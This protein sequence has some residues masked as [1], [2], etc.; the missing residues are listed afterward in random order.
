[1]KMVKSSIG[2]IYWYHYVLN[3]I[4]IKYETNVR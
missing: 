1:M 2:C 4:N 3:E